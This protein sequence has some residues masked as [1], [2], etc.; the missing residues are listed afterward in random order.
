[1]LNYCKI[2]NL[3]QHLIKLKA[4][5]MSDYKFGLITIIITS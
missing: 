5:N 2:I 1:M 4:P 3:Q